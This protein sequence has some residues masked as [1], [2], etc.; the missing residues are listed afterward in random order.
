MSE[1][2]L[3]LQRYCGDNWAKIKGEEPFI[4]T[5]PKF[6]SWAIPK[7]LATHREHRF[8]SRLKQEIDEVLGDLPS[9][10]AR[11]CA[12]SILLREGIVVALWVSKGHQCD[13][14]CSESCAKD[15]WEKSVKQV[16]REIPNGPIGEN[17]IYLLSG[18]SGPETHR[19]YVSEDSLVL[20]PGA[21]AIWDGL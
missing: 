1:R 12:A 7:S 20:V 15:E 3:L 19:A 4:A 16:A 8:V 5:G 2:T 6:S 21:I 14:T 13:R 18:M 17:V 10:L 9:D 11:E